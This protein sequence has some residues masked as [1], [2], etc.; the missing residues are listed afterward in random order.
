MNGGQNPQLGCAAAILG[1]LAFAGGI[2]GMI[3]TFTMPLASCGP[4]EMK[5]TDFNND[6][7]LAAFRLCGDFGGSQKPGPGLW[8]ALA[9]GAAFFGG[10]GAVVVMS[11]QRSRDATYCA[12]CGTLL[13]EGD[14]F[15]RHCGR[16][17]RM[18]DSLDQ[19]T[20]LQTSPRPEVGG[21]ASGGPGEGAAGPIPTPDESPVR[22]A[23]KPEYQLPGR[24][25]LRIEALVLDAPRAR[26]TLGG[27]SGTVMRR[28]MT[29]ETFW[30][31]DVENGFVRVHE[32]RRYG[33]IRVDA[34]DFM[35]KRGEGPLGDADVHATP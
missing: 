8:I 9:G 14:T 28:A 6:L 13:L 11:R 12:K 18:P 33:Y 7:K 24:F 30:V 23:P 31:T 32:G 10:G 34:F 21:S 4:L 16:W 17:L 27:L 25:R 35:P 15:C 26:N 29:G 2:I 22:P 1:L 3:A 19:S 20:E 5:L